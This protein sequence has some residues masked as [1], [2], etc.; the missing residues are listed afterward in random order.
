MQTEI[1]AKFRIESI[2]QIRAKLTAVGATCIHPMRLMKRALIEEPHHANENSF[3]RIRDEGDRVTLTY[4][5]REAETIHGQKE[6]EVVVSDFDKTVE[7]FS[8]A[9]WQ[10]TTFQ[11][12]RR[13]TWMIDDAEVV[14][15]EW[16]W[17]DPYIEIEADD[18]ATLR[19]VADKLDVDWNTANL[20]SVD[21]FYKEKY[22]SMTV[23]GVIDIKEVR[24]DAPLPVE[25]GAQV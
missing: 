3:I 15:D 9:G 16:P 6:V 19:A 11:E 1:E 18:E 13:E 14:I 25:F 23:R 4:K 5:R 2:E 20:G 12:S 8:V 21:N 10:Y 17:V 7:L 24:F 22:P